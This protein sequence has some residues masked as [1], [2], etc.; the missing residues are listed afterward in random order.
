[1]FHWQ[2]LI[3]YISSVPLKVWAC[4]I[5]GQWRWI[6]AKNTILY[7]TILSWH[8]LSLFIKK[9]VFLFF[10]FL[11]WQSIEFPQQNIEQSKTWIG[12]LILSAQLYIKYHYEASFYHVVRAVINFSAHTAWSFLKH[13]LNLQRFQI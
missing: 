9:I 4:Y 6:T 3:T 2:F 12:D 7:L 10:S 8:F 11:F 5:M 1:M 13:I